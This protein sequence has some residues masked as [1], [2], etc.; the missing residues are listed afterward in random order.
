MHS[1]QDCTGLYFIFKFICKSYL[2]SKLKKAHFGFKTG[3]I[4]LKYFKYFKFQKI[5]ANKCKGQDKINLN[6]QIINRSYRQALFHQQKGRLLNGLNLRNLTIQPQPMNML[7]KQVLL[8]ILQSL[9]VIF[10][11]NS[12]LL[13][14]KC[15]HQQTRVCR[16]KA[17]KISQIKCV[18]EFQNQ[19]HEICK[20]SV[21]CE[22][23]AHPVEQVDNAERK[24]IERSS[25]KK[26]S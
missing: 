1:N 13:Y 14:I 20:I 23:G 19:R 12:T 26:F 24:G 11:I 7:V 10:L 9:H 18:L 22:V 16:S 4:F 6:Y 17:C 2:N 3:F 8:E 5:Y 25:L 15:M 21:L